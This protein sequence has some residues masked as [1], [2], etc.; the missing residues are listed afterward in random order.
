MVAPYSPTAGSV[1]ATVNAV[2]ADVPSI[3]GI[4]DADGLRRSAATANYT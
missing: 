4:D 2:P 1:A 3:A